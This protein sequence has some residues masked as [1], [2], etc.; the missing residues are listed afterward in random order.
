MK[1]DATLSAAVN[2]M[3]QWLQQGQGGTKPPPGSKRGWD[4]HGTFMHMLDRGQSKSWCLVS[5]ETLDDP[6]LMQEMVSEET[7]LNVVT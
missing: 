2:A 5:V 1:N 7:R 3:T 6:K 4:W